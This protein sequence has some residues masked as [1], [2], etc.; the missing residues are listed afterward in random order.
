MNFAF[1]EQTAGNNVF[2]NRSEQQDI[3]KEALKEF[4]QLVKILRGNDVNV[5]VVNDTLSPRTPDSIFPNNWVSFHDDGS[6]FLYPMQAENRRAERK[7]ELINRLKKDFR[8][9]D[10]Y[11]LSGFE[12][13]NRFLEGTGSMVLDRENK[14]VYSCLSPRTDLNVLNEFCRKSGYKPVYF[15]SADR[16]G[17]PV[18]HTNVM[19]C[20]GSEFAVICLDA[21]PDKHEKE[22]VEG[23]LKVTG[24]EVIEI[25]MD[26]MHRFAG[27]MLQLSTK[28]KEQL[29]VM[30]A[31]AFKSLLPQ[32]ISRLE[33]YC[34]LVY[35]P[36]DT[37]ES[38]GGGSARCMIAEIYLPEIR[39][40]TSI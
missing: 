40:I 28:N 15:Y 32:Q 3:Q 36:L 9:S 20:I 26:Q 12:K 33:H 8:V 14:I 2:Q 37:I 35:T 38:N 5:M 17:I 21:I 19:M 16:S 27:N 24:K 11:D 13:E 23:S 29:L 31:N 25:S 39:N 18:Y 30:S 4:D 1:N 34:K 22:K 7:P 10:V 6:V